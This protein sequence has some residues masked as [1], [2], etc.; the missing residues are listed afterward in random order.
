[1][2]APL[3]RRCCRWA[4]EPRLSSAP[5][6]LRCLHPHS[7]RQGNTTSGKSAKLSCGAEPL[8]RQS[9]TSRFQLR[10]QPGRVPGAG[11][12]PG[13]G[14]LLGDVVRAV[15]AHR[16]AAERGGAGAA[17]ACATYSC[18]DAHCPASCQAP[19]CSCSDAHCPASC[20]APPSELA[21]SIWLRGRTLE[22]PTSLCPAS[23]RLSEPAAIAWLRGRTLATR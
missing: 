5:V 2:R 18:S 13:A 12:P 19:P 16:A 15:Q 6:P 21:A 20:Q 4:P 9:Q 3:R 17:P 23:H 11:R 14:G 1:M 22:S 7:R 10:C 8:P